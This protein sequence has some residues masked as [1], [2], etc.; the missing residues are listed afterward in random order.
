MDARDVFAV[1]LGL[2]APWKL[3]GQRLDTE[4][5]P[6]E[7]HLEV[8]AGRGAPFACPGC[9]RGCKAHDFA[10]FTWKHLN[11][12]QHHCFIAA[13]VPLPMRAPRPST[14][15][16]KRPELAPAAIEPAPLSSPSSTCLLP[17]SPTSSNPLG[18]SKRRN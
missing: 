14:A 17:C 13:R 5:R 18:A 3:A 6:H 8:I 7:L 4:K 1:G 10:R 16:S 15:S 9:G 11:F 2:S 12:F